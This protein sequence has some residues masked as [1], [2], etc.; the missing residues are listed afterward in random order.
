M[1]SFGMV[2]AGAPL[3][4]WIWGVKTAVFV[5]RIMASYYS[6]QQ[7]WATFYE[8]IHG[9]LYSDAS[10]VVPFGCGVLVLLTEKER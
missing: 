1:A 4:M 8:L 10:I 9:E 3:F 5:D 7:I 2:Y 6:P